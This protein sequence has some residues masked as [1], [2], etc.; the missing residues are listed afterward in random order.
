VETGTCPDAPAIEGFFAHEPSPFAWRLAELRTLGGVAIG[1]LSYPSPGPSRCP[2]NLTVHAE[3]Y[4]P[5][6]DGPFP[7][8]VVL[9][10][11]DGR[12]Y[13][14]RLLAATLAQRGVAALFIQLPYYGDRRPAEPIDP[15]SVGPDDVLGAVRQAVRDIRR[16]AAWLRARPEVDNARVG[17]AGVS[18]GA[19]AAE[20]AAG[21]DGRFDRCVFALGGGSIVDT[22]YSGAREVRTA[23]AAIESR[24]WTRERLASKLAPI[25][26]LALAGRI[27]GRRVL[28][29][30]CTADEVVPPDSTRAYWAALD[31]PEIHWYAGGHYAIKDHA[32]EVLGLIADHFTRPPEGD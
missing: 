18:L 4:R 21:A 1:H 11:A 22:L 31:E 5:A 27:D 15:A 24:G 14:A 7:A 29:I 20:L 10:I 17:V 28:M 19:F 23:R 6:G 13:V 32:F 8:A 16:G 9:H 25:E 3:Y 26:P 2:E 12:F 30:N